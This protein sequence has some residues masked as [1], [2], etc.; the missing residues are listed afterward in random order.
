MFHTNNRGVKGLRGDNGATYT[1][2]KNGDGPKS[3]QPAYGPSSNHAAVVNHLMADGSVHSLSKQI[4]VAA[5]MFLITRNG[6]DPS[7]VVP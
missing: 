6:S 1:M 2:G 4:D 3:N 7:P 5:Y